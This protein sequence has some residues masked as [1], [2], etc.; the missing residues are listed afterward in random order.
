MYNLS[1]VQKILAS[2]GKQSWRQL[3]GTYLYFSIPIRFFLK[4]SIKVLAGFLDKHP[5]VSAIQP[6][7]PLRTNAFS[8]HQDGF[9]IF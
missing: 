2:A 5:D 8:F 3:S 1:R 4:N 9:P 6:Q 7:D